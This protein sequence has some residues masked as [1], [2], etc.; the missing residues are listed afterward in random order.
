MSLTEQVDSIRTREDFVL[1]IR[2][3]LYSLDKCPEEWENRDLKSY[4]DAL[5]AWVEDMDGYYRN[6]GEAVPEQLTWKVLGDMVV[7]AKVY[8]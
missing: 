6:L 5:A 8:E 2:S 3:L 4:F 7:A 1:L